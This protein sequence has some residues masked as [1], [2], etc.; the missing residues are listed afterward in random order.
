MLLQFLLS[1]DAAPV[2]IGVE[3][4]SD[5]DAVGAKGHLATS[6]WKPEGHQPSHYGIHLRSQFSDPF[7]LTN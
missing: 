1:T 2:Y 5:G 4:Q 3:G 7:T 6:F